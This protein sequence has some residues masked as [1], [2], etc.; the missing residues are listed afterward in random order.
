MI[1]MSPLVLVQ[2]SLKRAQRLQ[3]AQLLMARNE[4]LVSQHP[5]VHRYTSLSHK[6]FSEA[7]RDNWL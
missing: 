5:T 3:D 7:V 2:R 1:F 4:G 6:E